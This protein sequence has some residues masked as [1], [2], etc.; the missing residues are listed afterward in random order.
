[1][2]EHKPEIITKYIAGRHHDYMPIWYAEVGAKI[3]Q[4]MLINSI[5]PYVGLVTGFIIPKIK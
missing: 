4:T 1:M 5:L 3:V 2:S